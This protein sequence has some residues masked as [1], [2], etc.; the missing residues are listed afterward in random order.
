MHNYC[1]GLRIR[2]RTCT[3]LL[4]ILVLI[5]SQAN[6]AAFLSY[7]TA[8]DDGCRS[9]EAYVVGTTPTKGGWTEDAWL[10]GE[11]PYDNAV[12]TTPT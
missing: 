7:F 8:P 3:V 12:A 6:N 9:A 4:L 11:L 5:Y 1:V 10:D 2:I